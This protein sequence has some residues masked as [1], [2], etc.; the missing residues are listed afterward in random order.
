MVTVQHLVR[1]ELEINPILIDMLQQEL[2]NVNAVAAKILPSI[3]KELRHSVKLAAVS[4]AIRRIS[5]DISSR[6]IYNWT[7][8]KNLEVATKSQ[9][10]EV[11]IE[12][13]PHIPK[14]LDYL[15]T[16]INRQKGEFL[17]VVE[18]TYEILIFTNQVNKEYVK[19]SLKGQ[20]ITSELDNVGY[21]TVNWPK[22]TKDV[23]G[24]YY[25]ITRALAFKGISIQAFHTIGAEMMIVFKEDVFMEAYRVI[26]ELMKAGSK[27]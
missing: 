27:L 2:V 5:K 14:I 9:L 26:S 11:A 22:L 16:H 12:K 17:T 20:K 23:P 21:V 7:F 1:K 15:Y 10:Y 24:I 13:T 8:P 3:E 4:M 19:K 18:G 25:R 6:D